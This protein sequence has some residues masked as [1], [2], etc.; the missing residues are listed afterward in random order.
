MVPETGP[1]R[2]SVPAKSVGEASRIARS[3]RSR[4]HNSRRRGPKGIVGTIERVGWFVSKPFAHEESVVLVEP[5]VLVDLEQAACHGEIVAAPRVLPQRTWILPH[6]ERLAAVSR[7]MKSA[8]PRFLW[9]RG[10][11]RGRL[12]NPRTRRSCGGC[13]RQHVGDGIGDIKVI[14]RLTYSV[15]GCT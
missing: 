2:R 4:S 11:W 5:V 15:T 3:R 14:S 8:E 1:I 6:P 13:L 10:R 9:C 7:N 12:R